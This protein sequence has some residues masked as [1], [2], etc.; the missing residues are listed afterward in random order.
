MGFDF[1]I[2]SV[3]DMIDLKELGRFLVSKS[4]NYLKYED[5]VQRAMAEVEA[6]YK[7]GVLAY[8]EGMLIADLV[9][10]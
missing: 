3:D 9:Y 7:T 8:S 1:N 5:C 2:R 10:Q 6:G 4:L